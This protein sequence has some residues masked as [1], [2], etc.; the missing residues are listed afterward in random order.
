MI[1]FSYNIN[2]DAENWVNTVKDIKPLWGIDYE[3]ETVMVPQGLKNEI[4]KVNREK[5]IKLVKDYFRNQPRFNYKK[6]VITS[7][8][9]AIEKIWKSREEKLFKTLEKITKRPIFSPYLKVY[10][11]TMFICPYDEKDYKW[12]MLSMWHSIPFQITIICHEV[13]HFQFLNY[14]LNFCKKQG[15]NQNQIEN[16]KESLTVLLNTE[17]F[18]N[19]IL[20]QDSGYPEHQNL[21]RKIFNTWQKDKSSY[22]KDKEGFEVFLKEIIKEIK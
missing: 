12:F 10:F 14:Y 16:L 6:R 9:K 18:D 13:F 7:E 20:C 11:T 22:L 1:K 4:L 17:K 19:I 5:A 15:L 3:A 21:R 8:I 2:K